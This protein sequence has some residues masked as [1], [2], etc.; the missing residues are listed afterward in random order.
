M[1]GMTNPWFQ[2]I[3]G[4]S[5]ILFGCLMLGAC[6][7]EPIATQYRNIGVDYHE[8]WFKALPETPSLHK[9][10]EI[11]ELTIHMVSDFSFTWVNVKKIPLSHEIM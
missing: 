10:I 2:M 4:R 6:V 5:L 8:K 9:V 7:G 3:W 1:N 11:T